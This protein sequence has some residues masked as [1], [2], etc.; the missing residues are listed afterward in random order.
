M[1]TKKIS[2]KNKIYFFLFILCCST[3]LKGCSYN[4]NSEKE[5]DSLTT[6]E[7]TSPASTT[8][9]ENFSPNRITYAEGFFFEPI[10][11][12]IQKR[13]SGKSYPA[14]CD[15]PLDN[16]RYVQV[17][18]YD[19]DHKIQTGELIV[20]SIIALDIV[21][22]FKELYDAQYPIEKIR[23]IDD[24]NANDDA[25][26]ADNNS[27]AFNYR[28]I[29]GTTTL[30]DHSYGM[31]IDINPLYNP[32]VRTGFGDRDVL[33]VGSDPYADRERDFPHKITKGDICYNAFISHGFLWGGEWDNPIDYQ[34][35]YKPQ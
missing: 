32:Y 9:E 2:W 5:T 4:N 30:S 18:Y 17:K 21:E 24:Y 26:M 14:G 10:S 7:P 12:S 22:I 11:D 29:D 15:Y 20:N 8:Q 27:S 35:F 1:K 23:L 28:F 31:A 25:S 6:T 34:H 16:L 33:P 13:I 3:C 19:F